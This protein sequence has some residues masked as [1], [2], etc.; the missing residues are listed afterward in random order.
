MIGQVMNSLF[1][2]KTVFEDG[3]KISDQYVL[4]TCPGFYIV[5]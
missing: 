5:L 1:S 3:V 4:I 2:L